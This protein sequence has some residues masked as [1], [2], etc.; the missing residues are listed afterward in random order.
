MVNAGDTAVLTYV[1]TG[2]P[3]PLIIWSKDGVNQMNDSQITITEE[4]VTVGGTVLKRSYLEICNTTTE[5]SGEYS[6]IVDNGIGDDIFN[7]TLTVTEGK[8]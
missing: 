3:L 4:V 6:C 1:A 5:D 8:Q 2:K 7:F